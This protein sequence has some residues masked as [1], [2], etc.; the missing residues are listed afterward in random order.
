MLRALYKVT[1]FFAKILNTMISLFKLRIA[2]LLY[3]SVQFKRWYTIRSRLHQAEANVDA[4]CGIGL[5]VSD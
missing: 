2:L 4:E 1:V 5:K 3:I